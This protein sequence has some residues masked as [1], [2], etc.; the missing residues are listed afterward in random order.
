[1]K[2]ERVDA[3]L[4]WL[5][6]AVGDLEA[7]R[8]Q[9]GRRVRPRHVA[10]NAQQAVEKALKAAL[11]LVGV[12]PPRSHDLDDLRNRLPNGWRVK[13]RHPDLARLSQYSVDSRYPDDISPVTPIQSATAVR[14]AVAVV[15]LVREDFERLG[16]S[17]TTLTPR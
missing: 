9:R 14:Q 5:G 17:T 1:M 4:L 16:V 6:Y 2:D 3:A 15:R 12:E 11:I 10:Y 13:N 8:S 7:A